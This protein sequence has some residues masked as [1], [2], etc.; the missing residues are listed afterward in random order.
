MNAVQIHLALNHAPLFFSFFG[1]LLLAWSMIRQQLPLQKIALYILVAG[2]ILTIPVYFSGENAEEIAESLAGINEQAMDTHEGLA[3]AS[4]LA[5]GLTG[6]LALAALFMKNSKPLMMVTVLAAFTTLV[7][8]GLTAHAGGKIRHTE[9]GTV[10]AGEQK[11]ER[12]DD[13]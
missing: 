7:I 4:L 6:I 3:K 10:V 11:S 12:H 1:G 5:A 13:D 2:A 9:L 8:V